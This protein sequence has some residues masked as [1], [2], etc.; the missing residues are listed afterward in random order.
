MKAD[1]ERQMG[2]C[3]MKYVKAG[4]RR[5]CILAGIESGNRECVRD[6]SA[7]LA[8]VSRGGRVCVRASAREG[9]AE[10]CGECV[11][12]EGACLACV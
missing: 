10:L 3:V 9:K 8:C 12:G 6:G 5:R 4:N 11:R 2:L 7:W 1:N